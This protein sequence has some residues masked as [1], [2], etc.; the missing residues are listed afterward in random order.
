MKIK[1]RKLNIAIAFAVAASFVILP[2]R[3][4]AQQ[5]HMDQRQMQN[6]GEILFGGK[7]YLAQSFVP[8]APG[9]RI[10][11][12]KVTIR[13]ITPQARALTLRLLTPGFGP[14]ADPVTIG[15]AAIPLGISVQLFEFGCND[16]PLNGAFHLLQLESP[17]S[18][19]GDY[20]WRGAGV[21]PYVQPANGGRGWRNID[22]GAPAQW[23][24]LGQWDFAFETHMCD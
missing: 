21:N 12:V 22:S 5:C 16:A 24:S 14:M 2:V 3:A 4:S 13:K 17:T 6:Q 15:P 18:R 19:V 20:A 8:S 1:P 7:T 11:R 10:C 9:Q 23:N